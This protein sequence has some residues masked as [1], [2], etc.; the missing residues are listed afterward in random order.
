MFDIIKLKLWE[1]LKKKEVSLAVVYDR[2]GRLL[3]HKGREISGKTIEEGEG[4][5]ENG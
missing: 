2:E 1:I 3:W 5:G 4:F